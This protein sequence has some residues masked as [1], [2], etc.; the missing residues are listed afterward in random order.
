MNTKACSTAIGLALIAA[1]MPGTIE[2]GDADPTVQA[3]ATA[4]Q[5]ADTK[6][7]IAAMPVIEK[8]WPQAPDVYFAN[9][10]NAAGALDAAAATPETRGAISNL[11]SNLIVKAV[12][13][14]PESATP[15]LAAKHDAILYFL[16]FREVREN[17]TNL[18]ALASY[19][20]TLRSQIVSNFVPRTVY[21]NPPGL[22]DATPAQAQQIIE[23]NQRNQAFNDWQQSLAT[24]NGTLTFLLLHDAARLAAKKS[25][26]AG[27]VR[28]VSTEARLTP[29]E[30]RQ[31]Q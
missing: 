8:L 11:F 25:E 13:S 24:A 5:S 19:V 30:Q 21:V 14:T 16:N 17:K 29:E 27:F 28:D 15:C 26:N 7:V 20:G 3:I 12:P 18:L 1:A 6:Q 10:K 23:E 4:I 22:L 2:A 9:M 31:L